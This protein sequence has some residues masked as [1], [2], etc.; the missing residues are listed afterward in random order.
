M[1]LFML[2]LAAIIAPLAVWGLIIFSMA[3]ASGSAG[4]LPFARSKYSPNEISPARALS[5]EE[6][7]EEL[8]AQA[9]LVNALYEDDYNYHRAA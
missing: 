5:P 1:S 6:E 3:R 4:P 7:A 8:H 9:R 2:D